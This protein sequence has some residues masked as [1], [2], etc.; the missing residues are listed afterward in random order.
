MAIADRI[1]ILNW[2]DVKNPQAGG[3]EKY[4]FEIAKRLADNGN[5]IIWISR[6]FRGSKKIEF[7]NG[8]KF[9]RLGNRFTV[10]P[11]AIL[12]ALRLRP[13]FIFDSINVIPFFTPLIRR[14]RILAMIHHIIPHSVIEQKIGRLSVFADFIQLKLV[15]FLYRN[16][17]VFA[18]SESTK[19]DLVS[20]GFQNIWLTHLGVDFPVFNDNVEKQKLVVA[21][22]ALRP[23]KRPDHILKAFLRMPEDWK[24]I[25]FGRPESKNIVSDLKVEINRLKIPDRV[26][27][28]S[29][30]SDEQRSELYRVSSIAAIASEKEG[31]GFAAIEPQA[32]GC[33]VVGYDVPGIRDSVVNNKTGILVPEGDISALS[34]ALIKLAKDPVLCKSFSENAMKWSKSFT[35]ESSFQDFVKAYLHSCDRATM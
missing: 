34:E 24:L 2:M 14:I 6:R 9:I 31:W 1:V 30:I 19:K 35:W 33:P 27:V 25:I 20:L 18:N 10:Y 28:L 15:P 29:D 21:A 17:L 26:Q 12:V 22:G 13:T 23:W 5:E 4:C 11:L 7:L 8:V 3:A 16:T 32:F